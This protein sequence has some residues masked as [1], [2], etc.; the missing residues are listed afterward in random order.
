M[1]GFDIETLGL[2]EEVPLPAITCACLHDGTTSVRLLFFDV[3]NKAYIGGPEYQRNLDTLLQMLDDADS[4]AAFNGPRFDI[5]YIAL[6]FGVDE[7]RVNAWM[8]KCIDPYMC[9]RWILN[10][11]CKLNVMLALNHMGSK[12]GDGANAILLALA[13]RNEELLK[14]CEMDAVLTWQV[15]T[16]AYGQEGLRLTPYHIGRIVDGAWRI[17]PYRIQAPPPE[18]VMRPVALDDV[19][20]MCEAE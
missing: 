8:R 7:A 12:T 17:S 2:M 11:T 19:Y 15:T 6:Y 10:R 20:S 14:Y 16:R 3:N 9:I 1:L 18:D 4:L 13:G 5:P